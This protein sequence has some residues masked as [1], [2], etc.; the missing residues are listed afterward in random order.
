MPTP[1]CALRD[2]SDMTCR[3]D[4]PIEL[5][6]AVYQAL[7]KIT[8]LRHLL[9]RLDVQPSPK[10][11]QRQS[12]HPPPI[13]PPGMP[14]GPFPPTPLPSTAVQTYTSGFESNI[15]K[16]RRV[17]SSK[18]WAKRRAFSG[19][20]QL[21][22]LEVVG[23]S[24]L[25]CLSEIAQ[26][27]T[28]S[29]ASLKN[30]TLTLS[31]DLARKSRKPTATAT[32]TTGTA[33]DEDVSDTDIDDE[34]DFMDP[35]LPPVSNIG[36]PASE[37]DI[38]EEKLAQENILAT[39]FDLQSVAQVGKKLEKKLSLARGTDPEEDEAQ[40]SQEKLLAMMKSLK[41]SPFDVEQAKNMKAFLDAYI[42]YQQGLTKKSTTSPSKS[43]HLDSIKETQSKLM[44]KKQ[45][46]QYNPNTGLFTLS[47]GAT[48]INGSLSHF[49]KLLSSPY[50]HASPSAKS[51]AYDMHNHNGASSYS[52]FPLISHPAL[53]NPKNSKSTNAS[54]QFYEA[55]S[56]DSNKEKSINNEHQLYIST[57][58]GQMYDTSVA[59]PYPAYPQGHS[60]S[61][62]LTPTLNP[63][64]FQSYGGPASLPAPTY[65]PPF[66]TA[67]PNNSTTSLGKHTKPAK[68]KKH[69]AK[70][71][72]PPKPGSP[73][74]S[75]ESDIEVPGKLSS[76]P[77]MSSFAAK[78]GE[79]Q[80][81]SMDVDMDH[82]D[83][84][85]SDVGEDQEHIIEPDTKP[86]E[87]GTAKASEPVAEPVEL[88]EGG[89]SGSSGSG[90]KASA[91]KPSISIK[92]YESVAPSAAEAMQDYVRVAHGLQLEGIHL[93]YIPL[94]ASIIGRALDLTVLR[95]IT[96]LD[97]G[98]Q[99]TFWALLVR[100]TDVNNKITFE[101]IHT[102]HAS[103]AF[104]KFLAT[105]EGLE[106]LFMHERNAKNSDTD[107]HLLADISGLRK[108]A[109]NTHISTLRR[110]MI[111][112]ERDD[113]WDVDTKTL[114]FLALKGKKLTELACSMKMQTYV[115]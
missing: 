91:S 16:R 94:K 23:I 47:G 49:D 105:F 13:A 80:I 98:P 112:N 28:A 90:S 76:S 69:T 3:W 68:A 78:G 115:S 45:Q 99:D 29:S 106:E 92:G 7:H 38:R 70:K 24:N 8:S 9:V 87:G 1:K 114:Q 33:L 15:S 61:G 79:P 41:E 89:L 88:E 26:C 14:P 108:L 101:R 64:I 96:L 32:A 4:A 84:A 97:V 34:E 111:R 66:G 72:K 20:K 77:D 18:F 19:F 31:P 107:P 30:L 74:S 67:Y 102:D 42:K 81:D 5:S 27:I 82:P 21:N 37:A 54:P 85:E 59:A 104:I 12:H 48:N 55:I 39:V 52:N 73:P 46:H 109:L 71:V 103:K 25:D 56:A 44:T 10:I 86:A 110:I 63:S 40:T 22:T 83:E 57:T 58:S 100:L 6:S 60:S 50:S 11:V 75:D 2:L 93:H 36:Q 113:S 43:T 65:V 95:R 35:P 53:T 51:S 17:G 62:S